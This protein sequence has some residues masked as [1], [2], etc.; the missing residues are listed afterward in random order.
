MA[1]EAAT[2]EGMRPLAVTSPE[3]NPSEWNIM[4][5]PSDVSDGV[6]EA[7]RARGLKNT[8][9]FWD[10][11][12]KWLQKTDLAVDVQLDSEHSCFLAY[13]RK[14]DAKEDIEK[15]GMA[16]ARVVNS[17]DVFVELVEHAQRGGH[18]LDG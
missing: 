14:S 17:V 8:G 2:E 15:L 18:F 12:V 6:R 1:L 3:E 4:M 13:S 16:L 11:V 5:S 10:S 7:I 9:Y